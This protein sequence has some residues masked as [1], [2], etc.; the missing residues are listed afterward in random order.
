MSL[1]RVDITDRLP[2]NAYQRDS[3][4]DKADNPYYAVIGSLLFKAIHTPILISA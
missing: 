1:R 3:I 4:T 2:I